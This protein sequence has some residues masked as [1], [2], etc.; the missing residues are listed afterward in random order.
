MYYQIA[1]SLTTPQ[2]NNSLHF[3]ERKKHGSD[4]ILRIPPLCKWDLSMVVQASEWICYEYIDDE[5]QQLISAPGLESLICLPHPTKD[6]F[7]IDNHNHAFSCWWRSYQK[8]TITRWSHLIHLD[9]HSDFVDATLSLEAFFRLQWQEYTISSSLDIKHIDRYS[10]EILTIASFIKP[11]LECQLCDSYTMILS[12]Y[13]LL[14]E[15][16]SSRQGN[17]SLI[18]DIDLDF[19]APEMSIIEYHK[20][21]RQVQKIITL[22]TV[23]CITIATSP[24]YI[25]HEKA[26][27]VLYDILTP[28]TST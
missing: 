21:I 1:T 17:S 2:G 15:P 13:R 25:D 7:I 23:G 5:T 14:H 24:T 18:V 22:P 11:A 12:E 27:N 26:M 20:T 28:L 9:Q 19:W 3:Q 8:Q 4:S 6:I 16:I 10:N